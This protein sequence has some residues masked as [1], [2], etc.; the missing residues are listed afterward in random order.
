MVMGGRVAHRGFSKLLL[1]VLLVLVVLARALVQG[2]VSSEG[3][4]WDRLLV[5]GL[6]KA[7]CQSLGFP[8]VPVLALEPDLEAGEK[9]LLPEVVGAALE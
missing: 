3:A 9:V 6:P 4:R 7:V 5:V 1:E 8:C 2:P